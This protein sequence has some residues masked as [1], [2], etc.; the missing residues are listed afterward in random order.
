MKS[1]LFGVAPK[2]LLNWPGDWLHRLSLHAFASKSLF[3]VLANR[4]VLH[5][6]MPLFS[7]HFL[8]AV[9]SL[10]KLRPMSLSTWRV[11]IDPSRPS[12]QETNVLS[13][14]CDS[15]CP[16]SRTGCRQGLWQQLCAVVEG[17]G[18]VT[19]SGIEAMW[20]GWRIR[21]SVPTQPLRVRCF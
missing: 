21:G 20:M 4:H 8:S 18:W 1:Q 10:P 11:I 16:V 2:A 19:G 3:T 12:H 14:F 5:T 15:L 17:W 9:F 7:L 13:L 6:F